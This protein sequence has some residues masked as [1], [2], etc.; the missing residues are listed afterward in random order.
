MLVIVRKFIKYITK[1]GNVVKYEI[2]FNTKIFGNKSKLD[3]IFNILILLPS[4]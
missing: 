2:N 3:V 1:R 4:R